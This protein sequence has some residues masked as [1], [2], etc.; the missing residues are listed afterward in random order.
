MLTHFS[1]YFKNR[2]PDANEHHD[3]PAGA[4]GKTFATVYGG[5]KQ[6]YMVIIKWM[7][8]S[9]KANTIVPVATES[10][11]RSIY[12]L[13]VAEALSVP[14]VEKEMQTRLERIAAV[15]IPIADLRLIYEHFPRGTKYRTVAIKSIGDAVFERR[16]RGWAV[17]KKFRDECREYD[18]DIYAYVETKKKEQRKLERKLKAAASK[19][20]KQQQQPSVVSATIPKETKDATRD[21]EIKES[22]DTEETK[23]TKVPKD[24]K[25]STKPKEPEHEKVATMTVSAAVVRKGKGSKPTYVKLPL[26]E[27][28]IVDIQVATRN[29]QRG[30]AASGSTNS[31]TSASS[32]TVFSQRSP[33]TSVS[34]VEV[35][36]LNTEPHENR[37]AGNKKTK[38]GKNR[39]KYGKGPAKGK[40]D[41]AAEVVEKSE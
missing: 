1:G 37:S 5:A 39:K 33:T 14:L 10:F 3:L 36:P 21:K 22:K 26:L 19:K 38:K 28:N 41:G 30:R 31:D 7:I 2:F 6:A 20:K 34:S 24:T 4:D 32:A 27:L 9:C 12:I 18:D 17:Y 23:V 13:Q 15:Q 25:E 29:E 11:F 8:E 35:R 16:L 40:V